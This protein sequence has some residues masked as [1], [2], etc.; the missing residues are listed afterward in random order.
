[1]TVKTARK[2]VLKVYEALKEDGDLLVLDFP[3]PDKLEDFRNPM[4]NYGM[5]Y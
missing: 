4:Y 5:A 3:Y 1:M 2:S